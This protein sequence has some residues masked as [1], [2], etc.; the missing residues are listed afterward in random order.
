MK[1]ADHLKIIIAA[2]L[3]DSKQIVRWRHLGTAFHIGG[4]GMIATCSHIIKSKNDNEELFALTATDQRTLAPL[5]EIICHPKYD[6]AVA[7][8]DG[9]GLPFPL[10]YSGERL[11]V[12]DELW[13]FSYF[14]A[15]SSPPGYAPNFQGRLF[16]G[17]IASLFHQERQGVSPS[18]CEISFPSIAGFSGAPLLH[19]RDCILGMLYGN[20]ES[21]I[22][23]YRY[24]E[25]INQSNK[26]A[27]SIH[28]LVEFG[29]AHSAMDIRRFLREM[30]IHN[31]PDGPSEAAL[32]THHPFM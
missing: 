9:P 4:G 18:T 27:E 19:P 28:R 2:E 23:L 26:R 25:V 13:A 12:G 22:E 11:Y 31:V 16:K 14:N 32:N 15:G 29:L 24:E 5:E 20:S 21:T 3:D 1:L 17:Y 30:G 8:I 10:I 7:K 6:F